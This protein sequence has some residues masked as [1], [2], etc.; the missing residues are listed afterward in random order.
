MS[1]NIFAHRR[2]IAKWIRQ[3]IIYREW[4]RKRGSRER[5]REKEGDK[6]FLLLLL[7]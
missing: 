5:I 7:L 4:G 2:E 1:S 3:W 6:N